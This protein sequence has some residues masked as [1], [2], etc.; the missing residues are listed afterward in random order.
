MDQS[1]DK[2]TLDPRRDSDRI[3]ALLSSYNSPTDACP[4]YDRQ[5]RSTCALDPS[6]RRV[7]D[8]QGICFSDGF[9]CNQIIDRSIEIDELLKFLEAFSLKKA[10]Y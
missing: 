5:I 2:Q 3:Q 7:W 10:R 9:C 1:I 8:C 4:F 6:S